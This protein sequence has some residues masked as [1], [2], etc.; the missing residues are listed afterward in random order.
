MAVNYGVALYENAGV[1]VP[2]LLV[3]VEPLDIFN[4]CWQALG[5]QWYLCVSSTK[6]NPFF[7]FKENFFLESFREREHK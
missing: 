2:F 1:W 5:G 3:S 4:H 7:F 6:Q